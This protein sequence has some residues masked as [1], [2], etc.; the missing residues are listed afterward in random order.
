MSGNRARLDAISA[1]IN[2]PSQGT[3][4]YQGSPTS[5]LFG[6]NVFN[7]AEMKKRLPKTVYKSLTK[8]IEDRTSI[9]E[10]VADVV[11]SAMREW[12]MERG[13]T[14]YAHIFFPLTGLSAEKHDSF[15]SPTGDGESIAEFSGEQLIQGEPDGSSFPTGGV[16]QTFEARGY[17]AWD[18]TS[19]AYI[20]ENE[21]GATLCIPTAFVSWTG[22]ALD[23]KTPLLR[24]MQALDT[25]ARRVLALFGDDSTTKVVSSAGP[26][27][28]YFLVDRNFYYA[29]PDLMTAGRTLF[30][31][32]PA[33]GQQFDDHYFGAIESRVLACMF[34]TERELVKLGVP[35]ATRHN[36]VAPGQFEIAPVYEDGNVAADH[37]Q[38]MMMML[39]R[40]AAKHGLVAILHE[41]PFADING[42]GKHLNFSLGNGS[43]GNLLEPG[44]TP[45]DNARFLTFCAAVIRSVNMYAP[46]LR[47]S[48]ASASNDHRLGANEAPPAIM[49]IFLGDQ[50]TDIFEQI[51]QSGDATSSKPSGT[52]QLGVDTLPAL[53][54]HSGDRNRTSPIAFT[55]NKFEYRAV[56]STQTVAWPLTIWNLILSESLDYIAAELEPAAGNGSFESV[57]GSLLKKI[58]DDHGRVIFNGDGYSDEWHKEAEEERGLPNLRTAADC[59]PVIGSADVVELFGK[60]DVL[61]E[62]EVMSRMDVLLEQYVMQVTVEA[63]LVLKMGR[64]QI[65]PAVLRTLSEMAEATD[66]LKDLG[67]ELETSTISRLGAL[68]NQLQSDLNKLEEML[69]Q[70][71]HDLVAESRYGCD[72]IL[73]HMLTIRATVDELEG[74]VDDNYWPLPSYQEMLSIK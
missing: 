54:K 10:S 22:E 68:A 1:A 12:A 14:H 58:M 59:L 11:A 57:L 46:L 60:Y 9:D 3:F 27:Q 29:R 5:E 62:R 16:R 43:V 8:T 38:I 48:V 61:S 15:M 25:Q 65:F 51:Q 69:A 36:E 55:G 49:S 71:G 13:A 19:P 39:R 32:A 45:H 42:S 20:L 24:A 26:E 6:A 56:G 35:V 72:T 73:P 53:P 67:V 21:N 18:V 34:E 44:E 41:K 7:K 63:S 50:L 64:T 23:K 30:G 31:A 17:T 40:V 28:E 33:K 52:L 66:D 70:E 74:F 47:A 4:D 37:Q 2:S